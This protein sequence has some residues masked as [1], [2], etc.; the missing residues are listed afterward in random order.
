MSEFI[1]HWECMGCNVICIGT[2]SEANPV[3][4]NLSCPE[5]ESKA[6]KPVFKQLVTDEK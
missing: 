6:W 1:D 4:A 3:T 2:D 5:C